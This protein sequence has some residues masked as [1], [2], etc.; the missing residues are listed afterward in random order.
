MSREHAR[1]Q[2]PAGRR[3][4]PEEGQRSHPRCR[5]GS[6]AT[7]PSAQPG[8]KLGLPSPPNPNRTHIPRGRTAANTAAS[9]SGPSDL[10]PLTLTAQLPAACW[11]SE[12]LSLSKY[13]IRVNS[14]YW[15]TA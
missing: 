13:Q 14:A 15:A 2:F 8:A 12:G 5:S 11:W 9:G 6:P 7:E 4:T 1:P 3:G 10:R